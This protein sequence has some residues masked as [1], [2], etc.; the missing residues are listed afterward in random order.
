MNLQHCI[1]YSKTK[2]PFLIIPHTH[3]HQHTRTHTHFYSL[4]L[5][6]TPLLL[7]FCTFCCLFTRTNRFGRVALPLS[8]TLPL[9]FTYIFTYYPTLSH[10]FSFSIILDRVKRRVNKS[11]QSGRRDLGPFHGF[12][13]LN[14]TVYIILTQEF[15]FLY[16]FKSS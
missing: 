5:G 15:L 1:D 11:Y 12:H 14:L 4:L 8:S 13:D 7:H 10:F 3:T 16:Y 2:N 9:P 6:L